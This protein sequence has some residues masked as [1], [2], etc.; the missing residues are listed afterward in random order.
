[1]DFTPGQHKL[2]KDVHNVYSDYFSMSDEGKADRYTFM[3]EHDIQISLKLVCRKHQDMVIT[4]TT[5]YKEKIDSSKALNFGAAKDFFEKW[6]WEIVYKFNH[7]PQTRFPT[8]RYFSS[9]QLSW[10]ENLYNSS[11]KHIAWKKFSYKEIVVRT[12]QGA[13][14]VF[15][16]KPL[17][18]AKDEFSTK[19]FKYDEDKKNYEPIALAGIK[20][21]SP[22]EHLDIWISSTQKAVDEKTTL[23]SADTSLNESNDTS[24]VNVHSISKATNFKELVLKTKEHLRHESVHKDIRPF[25][26]EW[27]DENQMLQF[28]I[29]LAS[30]K[31]IHQLDT[32][33][34]KIL[35]T[36]DIG[37]QLTTDQLD[38]H[39]RLIE[40][41]SSQN[42]KEVFGNKITTGIM[43]IELTLIFLLLGFWYNSDQ[44]NTSR[45]DSGF[46][47]GYQQGKDTYSNERIKWTDENSKLKEQ[48]KKDSAEIQQMKMKIDSLTT[49]R[50]TLY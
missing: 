42:I 8:D 14:L 46:D 39:G 3:F 12:R 41:K 16:I 31:I 44:S 24:E 27:L 28:R 23:P 11:I 22:K 49:R 47:Q 19:Y 17:S 10:I 2:I 6:M 21:A 20:F 25:L 30:D 36:A 26:L 4:G 48:L 40:R 1:M 50:N 7:S 38:G 35:L 37:H 43:S 15:H 18:A 34:W 5:A 33:Q 32:D 45:Y 13:G 29:N 9:E